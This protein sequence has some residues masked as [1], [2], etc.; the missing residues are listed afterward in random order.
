M[1]WGN[2]N[3]S[4]EFQSTSYNESLWMIHFVVIISFSLLDDSFIHMLFHESLIN[5]KLQIFGETFLHFILNQSWCDLFALK[6]TDS[7]WIHD[8]FLVLYFVKFCR[9]ANWITY[10]IKFTWIR[11][12][13]FLNSVH[14]GFSVLNFSRLTI[15]CVECWFI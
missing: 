3:E 10:S 11:L 12:V 9:W 7:L 14:E 6:V 5:F 2:L 1:L 8:N 15:S 4:V 13:I